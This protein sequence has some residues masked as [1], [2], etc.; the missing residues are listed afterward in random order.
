[1]DE[2]TGVTSARLNDD[3]P[4]KAVDDAK[5]RTRKEAR[6]LLFVAK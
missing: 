4:G 6:G 1:M 2:E 5:A 3:Q